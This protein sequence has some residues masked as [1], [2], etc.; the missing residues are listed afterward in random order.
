MFVVMPD[1]KERESFA[2]GDKRSKGLGVPYVPVESFEAAR[3][4]SQDYIR[5]REAP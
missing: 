2:Q 5:Q 4:L 3:R 1:P